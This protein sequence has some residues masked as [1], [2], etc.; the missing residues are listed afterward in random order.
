M[1]KSLVEQLIRPEIKALHSYHVPDSSGY[2]K[3]DAMEN[4]HSWPGELMQAWQEALSRVEANRY[5][6][7]SA[8]AL[9]KHLR[10][11]MQLDELEQSS[12]SELDVLLG[13]GSDEIIQMI[14]MALSNSSR[15]ILAPE[16]SFVMYGMI[17]TFVGMPYHGVPL[18]ENFEI[19]LDAF[20]E[21]D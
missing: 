7:P 12:G 2:L 14:A 21:G 8:A 17:A 10:A 11:L 20:L 6:D 19:D 18:E 5:P 15:G 16:P 1:S 3:L 13:N 9:K 4:P